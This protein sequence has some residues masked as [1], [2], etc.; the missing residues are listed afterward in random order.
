MCKP[1][2][3][4][5]SVRVAITY[6]MPCS[7]N[8]SR[9]PGF[10][11]NASSAVNQA[12]GTRRRPP[13]RSSPWPARVSWRTRR[14]R[15]PP[16]ACTDR[17]HRPRT[18]ADT[19]PDRSTPA[20]SVRHRPKTCRSGSSRSS[21]QYP[22]TAAALPP[23]TRP[24]SRTRCPRRSAHRPGH[25]GVR[26]DSRARH[27]GPDPDPSTGCRVSPAPRSATCDRHAQRSSNRYAAPTV[28]AAR[29]CKRTPTD[30][31]LPV[32]NGPRSRRTHLQDRPATP[33][34]PHHPA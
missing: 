6:A 24:S 27:H 7:C 2:G 22:S 30:A 20:L 34:A 14:R 19:T 9:R 32:Q 12:N 29:G 31:V 3:T 8:Q 33:R 11:P 26:P 16:F 5:S 1:A 10:C 4:S 17:G 28:R 21:R 25:R 23:N 18:S 15:V 13:V